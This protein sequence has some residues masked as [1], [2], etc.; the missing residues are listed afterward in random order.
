MSGKAAPTAEEVAAGE[1]Q[2][3][4]DDP[5]H[6][7]LPAVTSQIATAIPEFWLTALRNH[8]GISGLVTD[9]DAAALK[10]LTD[11]TVSYDTQE[12]GT[13]FVLT[14]HF[15]ANDFF[16]NTTLTKTYYYKVCLSRCLLLFLCV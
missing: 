9:R 2:S 3:L 10:H 13:G 7:P 4:K 14:F 16:E 11:I 6:T 15:E 5:E 1:A 8:L 12:K